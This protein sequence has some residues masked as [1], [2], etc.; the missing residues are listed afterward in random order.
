MAKKIVW[1]SET[2][3]IFL[4]DCNYGAEMLIYCTGGECEVE[5]GRLGVKT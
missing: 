1:V 3:G 5:L 2:L 4:I